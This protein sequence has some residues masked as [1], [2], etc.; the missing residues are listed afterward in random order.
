VQL[1]AGVDPAVL[2]SEPFAVEEVGACEVRAGTDAGEELD[3]FEVEPFAF[4]WVAV[5]ERGATCFEPEG[6]G[7]AKSV[8]RRS[9]IRG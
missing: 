8:T 4:L 2:A 6:V 1:G 3:R 7:F 9:C 5:E